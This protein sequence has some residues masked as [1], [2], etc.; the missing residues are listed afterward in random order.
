MAQSLGEIAKAQ[1]VQSLGKIAAERFTC[2]GTVP[3]PRTV[4]VAYLNKDG[5]WNGVT[6]PGLQ[7]ADF[8]KII[9]SSSVASFGKGKET[10]TDKSYRDAY[11]L[12]PE[13]FL[14]SFQLSECGIL[15]EVRVS[16][17]PNVLNIQAELYKMNI[18]TAPNGCFKA[19]VDTPRSGNMFGS[20]V[21]CLPSQFTG[22][23]LLTRHHDQEV[24]YD[25]SSPTSDPVQHVQWA[26]FFSDVEHEILPVTSG[27]RATLT[28][29]LHHCDQ[30]NPVP[31]LEV[32]TTPFYQNLKAALGQPHF[33]REGGVLGFACQHS[34]VFEEFNSKDPKFLLKGSDRM[35]MLAATSLGLEVA[36]KSIVEVD[37]NGLYQ[38]KRFRYSDVYIDY[39]NGGWEGFFEESRRYKDADDITWCQE[40]K[41]KVPALAAL[42]YGNDHSTDTVYMAAAILVSVPKWSK[43]SSQ[44]D[45]DDHDT[46]SDED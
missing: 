28:Y 46:D 32:T 25:W 10:V 3:T 39:D 41:Q 15:G 36:V 20:L 21:V 22:G 19:H 30:L 18:Y 26:A 1:I 8:Q 43:R 11:A 35:V 38:S 42:C 45:N 5:Q 13:K 7:D 24:A 14:T 16:L 17:V 29:N 2:G 33:L 40:F 37:D 4:Q 27:Y 44:H 34:Y 31:S 23:S 9:E 6:F 12:E